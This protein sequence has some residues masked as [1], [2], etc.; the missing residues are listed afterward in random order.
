MGTFATVGAASV[1]T[2]V[3][4]LVVV[5]TVTV[6]TL[7]TESDEAEVAKV[8]VVEALVVVVIV[9]ATGVLVEVELDTIEV[10]DV[11]LSVLDIVEDF[12]VELDTMEV[13]DTE[14]SVLDNAELFD[15]VVTV[16]ETVV[17]KNMDV[18]AEDFEVD[19]EVT[20]GAFLYKF[21]RLAPP[22]YS[23]ELAAQVI[24]QPFWVV[25]LP[26]GATTAPVLIV[27]PQ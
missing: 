16:E 3:L 12:A 5:V 6:E 13:E 11:E 25:S 8:V 22:Q 10:D 7:E 4:E 19:V 23:K 20:I 2:V 1:E 14:I 9:D 24:E 27:F 18:E 26:P 21:K 17:V 15:E